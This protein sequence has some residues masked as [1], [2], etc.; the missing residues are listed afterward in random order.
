MNIRSA[1]TALVLPFLLALVA[2]PAA[3][4]QQDAA[5]APSAAQGN[6][7]ARPPVESAASQSGVATKKPAKAG[8][9]SGP[10]PAEADTAAAAKGNKAGTPPVAEAASRA[11]VATKKPAKPGTQSGAAPASAP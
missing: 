10:A 2:S 3:H 11:G 7:A 5:S 9:Q 4:A 1:S 8:A 6:K